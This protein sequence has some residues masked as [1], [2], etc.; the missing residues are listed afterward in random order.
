MSLRHPTPMIISALLAVAVCPPAPRAEPPTKQWVTGRGQP[1]ATVVFLH[2]LGGS[3]ESVVAHRLG[4]ALGRRGECMT[5]VV[6][7]LRPVRMNAKGE[8]V[9]TGPHTMTDQLNRLRAVLEAQPGPVILVG[10]SFGGKAALKLAKDP[11]PNVRCIVALAPSVSMLHSYWKSMTG[12]RGLPQ[13]AAKITRGLEDRRGQLRRAAASAGGEQRAQIEGELEYLDVMRDLVQHNEP[14]SERGLARPLLVMHG[15]KDNAVSV[16][17][18]RRFAEANQGVRLV[19]L[20]ADHHFE[21]YSGK[22]PFYGL[23]RQATKQTMDR[24]ADELLR[25]R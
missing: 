3:P 5:M 11:P 16:H 23:D 12:E 24:I 9:A 13:D 1:T 15:E 18:V 6:P 19:E 2:G 4:Q 25:F 17:Y 21:V 20:P 8:P 10:H 7:W 22:G 14:E